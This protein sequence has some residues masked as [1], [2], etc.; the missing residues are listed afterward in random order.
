MKW[1]MFLASLAIAGTIC[2]PEPMQRQPQLLLL[3]HL[4]EQTYTHSQLLRPP[5]L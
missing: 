3:I 4:A 5:Y 1:Q 2:E